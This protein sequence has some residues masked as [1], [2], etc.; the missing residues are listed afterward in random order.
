MYAFVRLQRPIETAVGCPGCA[1]GRLQQLVE[2]PKLPHL[3]LDAP[4]CAS[5]INTLT[6]Y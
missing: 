2:A 1:D 3:K 5:L 4:A 6:I